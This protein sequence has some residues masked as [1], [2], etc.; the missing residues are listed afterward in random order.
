MSDK[1]IELT[2][3]Q[4][5]KINEHTLKC[6]PE[7]M[8]GFLT[9]DSFIPVENCS[10]EPLKSFVISALDYAKNF[11]KAIA[12][13]HSHTKDLKEHSV[14]D[15]RTP[16]YTDYCSQ[17]KTNLPWLIVGSEGL[18]VTD[19]IQF[20]RVPNPEFIGRRF[21]WF[22]N[23]CYNLVQDFYRFKL[24][25]ILPEQCIGKDY[26]SLQNKN[27]IFVDKYEHYGFKEIPLEEIREGDL[28]L[29]DSGGFQC[30]HL[31]IYTEGKVLHQGL[32]SCEVPFE[33]FLG[34]I[35]KVLRYAN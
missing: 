22:L 16:S 23:D 13:V 7:E 19:P 33:T 30:N 29:L 18:T 2:A 31:G 14:Y 8:C 3:Q 35:N 20:P 5:D 1:L 11:K 27:D 4:Q 26:Q 6:Y 34:R 17:K 9:E 25:I 21:Q 10:P 15:L 28:L 24:N 12:I 32:I